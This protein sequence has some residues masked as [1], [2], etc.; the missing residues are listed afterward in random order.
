MHAGYL[1]KEEGAALLS[2]VHSLTAPGSV[3]LMTAPPTV[4]HRDMMG[5]K[6]VKLHHST[7][8]PSSDTLAR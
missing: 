5:A 4:E 7:Y 3:L 2:L 6:G 8:E 1:S